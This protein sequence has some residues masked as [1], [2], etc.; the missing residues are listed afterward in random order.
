MSD[1][2][3][4]MRYT[5]ERFIAELRDIVDDRL[6][7]GYPVAPSWIVHAFMK[8]HPLPRSFTLK[9]GR[10]FYEFA[11]PAYVRANIREV[12]KGF[13]NTTE[14]D[15]ARVLPGFEF[16]QRA[17]SVKRE[18]E[19]VIVPTSQ[20]SDDELEAKAQEYEKM[21]A[22]CY[23]HAAEIRRYRRDRVAA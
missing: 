10:G 4:V 19:Q 5:R 12:L 21:G 1:D 8:T 9:R 23:E 13:E 20:L 7:R 6:A 17:Y 11:A 15:P 14:P 3:G 22:G 18:E 2:H 16:L